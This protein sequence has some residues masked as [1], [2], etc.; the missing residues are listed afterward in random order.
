MSLFSPGNPARPVCRPMGSIEG[1]RAIRDPVGRLIVSACPF[2]IVK[3]LST[4]RERLAGCYILADHA[5][6]YIGESEM[7]GRRFSEH[8][9]DPSMGFALEA[10]VIHAQQPEAL[11]RRALLYLQHRLTDI[12]KKAGLVEVSNNASPQAFQWSDEERAI[13]EHF[14]GDSLRL[15]FDAGCR[16]FHSNFVSQLS[17]VEIG[18]SAD[19]A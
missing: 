15:L 2:A 5:T 4:V 14:V 3:K 17:G 9:G 6:A 10:Y 7:I 1:P 16:V 19:D 18:V 12:A 11:S 13:Y 8:A